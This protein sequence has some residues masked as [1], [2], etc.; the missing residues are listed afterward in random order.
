MS[1]KIILE[2]QASF[3]REAVSSPLLLSDL[4]SMEKYISESYQ[5][6]SLIEL[7]QNADDALSSKF[8]IVRVNKTTYI[9]ANNG[10][11]FNDD[12]VISICRS[13][14]STKQRKSSSIGF[15]GIGL[16]PL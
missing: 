16:N 12:D 13:G 15:R 11:D 10:R 9:I 5:G 8:S 6:R 2:I 3:V 4:A 14:A 1:N 7:L